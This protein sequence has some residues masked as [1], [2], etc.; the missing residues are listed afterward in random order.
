MSVTKR[1]LLLGIGGAALGAAVSSLVANKGPQKKASRRPNVIVMLADDMRWDLM[2]AVGHRIIQ[3]PH[4]DRL[5]ASGTLYDNAFITTSVCPTSRA[6][7]MLGQMAHTHGIW[8]FNTP[9]S[10]E[11]WAQTYFQQLKEDGYRT[12]YIG[13][14]GVGDIP[15]P[16]RFDTFDGFQNLGHYISPENKGRHLTALHGD[17]AVQF[18][19]ETPQD[20]PYCM[21]VSFWAPH[22]QNDQA[23]DEVPFD[24]ELAHLYAQ[25]DIPLPPQYSPLFADGLPKF[26]D[27]HWSRTMFGRRHTDSEKNQRFVKGYYRLITGMDRAIGRIVDAVTKRGDL[28]NTLIVFLSDNGFMLGEHGLTGKWLMYEESIR[29]PMIVKYPNDA[30]ARGVRSYP[31]L[32][33]DVAPT[34]LNACSIT[35]PEG[36]QGTALQDFENGHATPRTH[37]TY[38]Y[39]LD[40]FFCLGIRDEH[41]KLAWYAK[42]DKSLLFDL[43]NDPFEERDLFDDETAAPA[44]NRLWQAL[45]KEFKDTPLWKEATA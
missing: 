37:F 12:G 31:A 7:I 11:Q 39:K 13:K 35:P 30:T 26:M 2:G 1:D 25:Q 36:T 6:S 18:V 38:E 16:N 42:A 10:D 9:L 15:N 24:V 45:Q 21:T 20:Q 22:S 40:P 28:D 33:I 5:A 23:D 29:I 4:L 17:N 8:D 27:E 34:I 14:W 44:R 32:N 19:N 41:W 43:L 3:T